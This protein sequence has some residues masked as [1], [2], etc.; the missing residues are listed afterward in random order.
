MVKD[1]S[2]PFSDTIKQLGQAFLIA[3]YL[4]A[5]ILMAVHLY[6]WLPFWTGQANLFVT[7]LKLILP[8]SGTVAS[9]LLPFLSS[10][11]LFFLLSVPVGLVLVSLNHILMRIFEGK[12]FWLQWG[13][14]RYFTIRNQKRC[15]E[16]EEQFYNELHDAQKEYRHISSELLYARTDEDK[17]LYQRTLAG[18][19]QQLDEGYSKIAR[20]YPV[21]TLPR[22][23]HRVAPT[24]F[25]NIYAMA[26][27]YAYERYG[28]DTVLFWPRLRPLLVKHAPDHSALL[29]QQKTRLDLTINAAFV[30]IVVALESFLTL[31]F[32]SPF[33]LYPLLGLFAGSILLFFGFYNAAVS[34]IHTLGELIKTSFDYYRGLVL[35]AFDIPTPK[36]LLI[37][38]DIWIK[39][40]RFIRWG[41]ETYLREAREIAAKYQEPRENETDVTPAMTKNY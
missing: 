14:L 39:L 25:G 7:S 17:Q 4:P 27:A 24:T 11:V 35:Q 30:S 12:V 2:G 9:S 23:V 33:Y 32:A 29:D 40:A 15:R 38:Q 1:I 20:K 13:L 36:H 3:Y 8:T 26:E 22:S 5:S 28:A 41:D 31:C 34:A 18:L 37:G 10:M 21:Q 16:Y 19:S 6:F